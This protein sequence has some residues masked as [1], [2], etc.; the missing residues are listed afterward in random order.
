MYLTLQRIL[1][2]NATI[3][4]I[5]TITLLLYLWRLLVRFHFN[6]CFHISKNCTLMQLRSPL[7]PMYMNHLL[8]CRTSSTTRENQWVINYTE[9]FI[10]FTLFHDICCI[11]YKIGSI[12]ITFPISKFFYFIYSLFFLAVLEISNESKPPESGNAKLF[13]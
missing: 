12:I 7:P 6:I 10:P 9:S 8:Q 2:S 3:N 1:R 11:M 4:S 13:S 5:C